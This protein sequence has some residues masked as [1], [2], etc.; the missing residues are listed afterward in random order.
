M[1]ART[2]AGVRGGEGREEREGGEGTETGAEGRGLMAV[3]RS[4]SRGEGEAMGWTR[5]RP[6][7]FIVWCLCRSQHG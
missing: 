3:E 6:S 4:A 5:I 7:S 1:E 2:R